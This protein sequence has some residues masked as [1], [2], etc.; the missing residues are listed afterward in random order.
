MPILIGFLIAILLSFY[1]LLSYW[2]GRFDAW[3]DV[4]AVSGGYVVTVGDR[5]E[6]VK[7]GKYINR[8]DTKR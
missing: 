8:I 7:S 1:S 6:C 5:Y 4:C 2:S 3:S